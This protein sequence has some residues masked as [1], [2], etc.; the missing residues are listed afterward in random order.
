MPHSRL[1]PPLL[2][3]SARRAIFTEGRLDVPE[4][5]LAASAEVALR[6]LLKTHRTSAGRVYQRVFTVPRLLRKD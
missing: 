3:T 4:D 6:K 5:F 2:T 1:G